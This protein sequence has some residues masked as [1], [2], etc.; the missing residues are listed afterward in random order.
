MRA[1]QIRYG[2]ASWRPDR[3]EPQGGWLHREPRILTRLRPRG[4]DLP[5]APRLATPVDA[6]D[7]LSAA[8]L[9]AQAGREDAFNELYQQVQPAL[10]RYLSVLVGRDAEDIASETWLQV[11]R[12]LHTF[13]GDGDGFRGWVIT[14]GRHRG[15]DHLRG[16][17]RRPAEP[18]PLEELLVLAGREDTEVLAEESLSTAAALRLIGELPQEQAE[19]VLLRAVIGLDAKTAAA[20]LGKSP[21]AVRTSAY[22]GLKTLAARLARDAP[23]ET[24]TEPAV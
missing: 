7:R 24:G 17:S 14:I 4:E 5:D 18:A 21:G 12:D 2:P 16:R 13:T 9:G 6:D 11:C 8:V 20:V 3:P 15:L 22:R 23:T 10:L 1:H 19:A